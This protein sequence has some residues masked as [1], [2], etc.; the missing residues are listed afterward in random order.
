MMQQLGYSARPNEP[1]T[2]RQ[3]R[4]VLF[5]LLGTIGDDPQV[6]QQARTWCRQYMKDPQS[7]DPTLAH[8]SCWWRRAMA[9]PNS[10]ASSRPR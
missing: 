6:I 1:P 10:T 9:T 7:V 5:N 4:A 8:R 2:E 3:R